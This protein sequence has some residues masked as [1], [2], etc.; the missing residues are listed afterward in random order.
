MRKH[1]HMIIFLG[2]PGAGKGTQAA[3]LSSVLG[4]PAIST[5]D[6]LRKTAAS[7]SEL[8]K[9]VGRVMASGELVGD[10]VINQVMAERLRSH[11]CAFGCILDG[12]PRTVAQARFL[13]SILE[14]LDM[15]EPIIFNFEVSVEKIVHRLSRR[16]HCPKCGGVFSVN[17][18]AES[19][20]CKKDRTVL[21]RRA[22]D[23]PE[24]IRQRLDVYRTTGADLIDFYRTR[25]Y[26]EIAAANTPKEISQ[27]LLAAVR[28]LAPVATFNRLS[29]RS[30]AMA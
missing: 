15:P 28:T 8:G 22:D 16:R 6:M 20:R 30:P 7:G 3:C 14:Q 12:Y 18:L 2:P 27:E 23:A 19:I 21:I 5:G 17:R 29:L 25:N 11:D 24:A 9:I 4:I 1:R 10:D 13:E 26:H